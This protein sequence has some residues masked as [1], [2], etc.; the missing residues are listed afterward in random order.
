MSNLKPEVMDRIHSAIAGTEISAETLAI[1]LGK[2]VAEV[3]SML[4]GDRPISSLTLAVIAEQTRTSPDYLLTGKRA[5]SFF[6]PIWIP[7]VGD[8]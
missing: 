4:S 5:V 1:Q 7:G 2:S 8:V 3:E 6:G